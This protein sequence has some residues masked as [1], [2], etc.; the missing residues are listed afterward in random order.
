MPEEKREKSLLDLLSEVEHEGEPAGRDRPRSQRRPRGAR[1]APSEAASGVPAMRL[2]SLEI[3]RLW[4]YEHAEIAFEEGVTVIAGPNGSGKSSLLESIFFALYGSKAGPAMERSLGDVLHIGADQGSVTLRFRY[5]DQDFTA[6][7]AL[8][9]RGE[10]VV[11]EREAC[12]LTRGDGEEWV[13]V[14]TMAQAVEDLF[15]M[16]RDDFTNCVYVRQGEIDRLIRVSEEERRG[17]IDRLLRLEKLDRYAQRAREGA[18]RAVNRRRDVLHH[19]VRDYRR[20]IEELEG[21]NLE[22]LRR[23]KERELQ[24][25]EEELE[26]HEA[27]IS[28]AEGLQYRYREDLKRME[29]QQREIEERAEEIRR[30]ERQLER[31]EKRERELQLD[32]ERLKKQYKDLESRLSRGLSEL[33]IPPIPV[34]ESFQQASDWEELERLP[35]EVERSQDEQDRLH[36]RIQEIQAEL[37][38]EIE[39]ASKAQERALTELAEDRARLQ[40]LQNERDEM[41]ALIAEGKCPTCRRPVDEGTFAAQLEERERNLGELKAEVEREEARLEELRAQ[42]GEL[43]EQG[44]QRVERLNEELGTLRARR[45][46]L[47]E[48]K[49][50]ALVMLRVKE[51]GLERKRTRNE[52]GE[53]IETLREEIADRKAKI[54]ELKEQLGDASELETKSEQLAKKL[55]ELRAQK[56]SVQEAVGTLHRELGTIKNR[57]EQL[58]NLKRAREQTQEELDHVEALQAELDQLTAFYGGL[59]REL[60]TRNI[61]AL[62]HYFNEFFQIMDPGASYRGVRVSPDYEIA[63]ELVDGRTIRPELLSGGERALINIALRTAIHQVLSQATAQMPLILDE[64]TIYLDRERVH[65][66]RF[67]LEELGARIGQVIFV[68]H[69]L[70]LVEGADHEYRTEKTSDNTSRVE[71]VR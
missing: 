55:D 65:R 7:M 49:E 14:E 53:A 23:E 2:E 8:R 18:R 16:T 47:E 26:A 43:K 25:K 41:R 17:M 50:R 54:A 37:N 3:D 44:K 35:R 39:E 30:K 56:R 66:L 9:R 22:R 11:S 29:E 21:K 15:G 62:E 46:R 67:L 70:G 6:G 32:H 31:H 69:E 61:E 68:S 52:L 51:Q 27:K 57:L 20:D 60:R 45:A 12:R 38:R 10:N 34:I 28:A 5:G 48:L 42:T 1:R 24:A 58:K 4:S 64:P 40:H 19:L 33:E 36:A 63:V 71:R 13:G 59:K